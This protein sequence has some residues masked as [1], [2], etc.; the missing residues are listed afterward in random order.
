MNTNSEKVDF[1]R[2]HLIGVAAA[3]PPRS[4]CWLR[5][6][7]SPT[8]PTLPLIKP[9]TT[10]LLRPA[11]ADRRRRPE[12][13]LCR[14][15]PR[16][17]PGGHSSARLALRHSQ[18][19][20]CR[21]VAGVGGLPGD[22]PV[23]ARLWHDALSFERH[24]PERPA[25]GARRRYHRLDGC[26]QDREGDPRRL[27]LGRADGQHHRGALAGALQGHGLRE[28]LSDRQP[29]SRQ[30]AA[31]AEGRARNGGTS[32]ISP[33]NAA[34]PATRNTGAI[35]RSSSG[36]SL[37]RSGTSTTPRSIAARRPSTIR[38]MS[39]IVIHNYRWRLGLAEGEPKYDD[40]EKRLAAGPGHHRAHHHPGR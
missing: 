16:R 30:D 9:G 4:V 11:E 36:S 22:R 19:C 17:W 12:C 38:I 1:H 25:V 8:K 20:R 24:A 10:R 3:A 31:A 26:A 39:R 29:G 6:P 32:S 18:L 35:S 34:G 27:R 33:P 13:R 14:S 23:S 2:R 15:R 21:A 28:R 40:L 7:H 5:P 37:R